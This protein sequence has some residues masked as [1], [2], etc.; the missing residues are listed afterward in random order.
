MKSESVVTWFNWSFHKLGVKIN[1]KPVAQLKPVKH[2]AESLQGQVLNPCLHVEIK[3]GLS[4][5][6]NR[7]Y[8]AVIV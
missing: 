1:Q 8:R 6:I 7:D 3:G 2:C 5:Q 4:V